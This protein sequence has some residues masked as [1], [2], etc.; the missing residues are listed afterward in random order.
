MNLTEKKLKMTNLNYIDS[1][2]IIKSKKN[3][4]NYGLKQNFLLKDK[5]K[6]KQKL[7]RY[8]LLNKKARAKTAVMTDTKR[9][10]KYKKYK[11]STNNF[12]V[13]NSFRDSK[14]MNSKYLSTPK[15]LLNKIFKLK[16]EKKETKRI[17]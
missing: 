14:S 3:L 8:K 11:N 13:T 5:L 12:N 15:I 6:Q 10:E 4:K 16:E 1:S 2:S 17:K 7:I 9:A